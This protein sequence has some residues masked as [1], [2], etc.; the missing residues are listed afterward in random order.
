MKATRWFWAVVA[1]QVLF[2]GL[3]AGYHEWVRQHAPTILLKTQPVDPQDLLRG[4]YMILGYEIGDAPAALARGD[5]V[6]ALGSE[7]WVLLEP[8][9]GFHAIVAI[10]SERLTPKPGQMLVR[11]E[12]GGRGATTSPDGHRISYGIETYFVPQ[13]KGTPQ[14]K[15]LWVEASVSP[16]HRLYI[17]RV[18]LDGKAYP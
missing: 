4:D 5:K 6:F 11:G 9:E 8:R 7:V 13:G 15:T 14:F 16:S 2:L 12:A 3:W 10:S 18:L 1:A 17:R